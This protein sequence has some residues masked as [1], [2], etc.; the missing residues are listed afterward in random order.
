[1]LTAR[2][3]RALT[4]QNSNILLIL[5]A[6]EA[7][8]KSGRSQIRYLLTT[9]PS[10]HAIDTESMMYSRNYVE[11]EDTLMDVGYMVDLESES[12]NGFREFWMVVSW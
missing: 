9:S 8:A 4:E 10:E 2:E 11:I 12:K 5:D 1:M 6:I 7:A 3:A